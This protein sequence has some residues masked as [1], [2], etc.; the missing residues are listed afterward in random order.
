MFVAR[1]GVLLPVVVCC[2]LLSYSP[3]LVV[4]IPH[5]L[6][7]PTLVVPCSW[8][9]PAICCS[10]HS[11]FSPGHHLLL[12]G[13]VLPFVIPCHSSSLL[14]IIINTS[15]PPYEQWL[16]GRVVVTGQK[17][18]CCNPASRGLQQQ[19]KAYMCCSV[20]GQCHS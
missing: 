1:V 14:F 8:W 5:C 4:P 17:R 12:M 6:S 20:G 19:H 10:L 7:F 16:A 13:L 11:L 15:I 2:S 3:F 18:A 9:F